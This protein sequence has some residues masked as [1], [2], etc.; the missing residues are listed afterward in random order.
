MQEKDQLKYELE[1]RT[2][3][4]DDYIISIDTRESIIESMARCMVSFEF[5]CDHFCYTFDP[6]ETPTARRFI[7]YDY[8][9]DAASTIIDAIRTGKIVHLD[10]SRDMGASWLVMAIFAW[11]WLFEED[12]HAHVGSR[13]EK[14]VDDYTIDSLFGKIDY[15]I[16]RLPSWMVGEYEDKKSRRMLRIFH[17]RG[18]LITGESANKNFGRGPRKKVVYLDEFAFWEYDTAVWTSVADTAP[19]RIVTSTP[20]G[21]ANQFARLRKNKDIVRITLHWKLHPL[22]DE[23]WYENEKKRRDS[24][25]LAQEVDINYTASSGALALENLN[26]D[27][28]LA[29]IIIPSQSTRDSINTH[30]KFFMGLDFGSTNPT[31]IH[32]Y[33]VLALD[34]DKYK[35]SSVWEYYEPSDLRRIS[36]A[37]KTCKWFHLVEGIYA[38]PS[39]WFYN[40]QDPHGMRGV[41]SL[42]YILRDQYNIHVKPGRRGDTYA[43]ENLKNMLHDPDNI[44]FEISVDCPHQLKEF[45]NLRYQKITDKMLHKKN[46]SEKLVDKDNH[47]WDDFKYFYNSYFE[48]PDVSVDE[49]I[50]VALGYE[51]LR[52]DF[53]NL[54][55]KKLSSMNKYK[56][57]RRMFRYR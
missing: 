44:L 14:L 12:F 15:I 8:Q 54:K 7:L 52:K 31:S 56:L 21:E 53:E 2:K 9:R 24:V 5:W 11:M 3:E 46:Q 10:K 47:S 49:S 33:R 23:E 16:E 25:S 19:C 28:Y 51:A 17:P 48:K 22:K 37:I 13:V 55:E 38:D 29:R 36:Q 27:E 26:N 20:D 41:T 43:L 1:K 50:P 34:K 57:R 30:C 6:R 4:I 45:Q 35:I 42:A 18:N 40:Q 39:M 32:V